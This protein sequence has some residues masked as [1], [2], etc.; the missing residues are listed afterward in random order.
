[1]K[2]S[3]FSSIDCHLDVENQ[4]GEYSVDLKFTEIQDKLQKCS[5]WTDQ[6]NSDLIAKMS[7]A[8]EEKS[9][10]KV[11]EESY[12]SV[13]ELRD[14]IEILQLYCNKF[15]DLLLLKRINCFNNTDLNDEIRDEAQV[16]TRLNE[17]VKNIVIST[18][19]AS[20]IRSLII[21]SKCYNFLKNENCK[22]LTSKLMFYL[23]I[24]PKE[25]IEEFENFQLA[26]TNS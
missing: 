18:E 26:D 11:N 23:A 19:N 8:S 4:I 9:S 21:K 2:S 24:T 14:K 17:I 6:M 5:S 16:K 22:I 10:N 13:S 3:R 12:P 20:F 25:V 7:E 15:M 1:M